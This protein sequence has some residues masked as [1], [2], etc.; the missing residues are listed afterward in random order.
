MKKENELTDVMFR[1]HKFND[2]IVI[3]AIFPYI[4]SNG[5]YVMC[6]EHIGQHSGCSLDWYRTKTKQVDLT[7]PKVIELIKELENIGY[8]LNIIKRVNHSKYLKSYYEQYE[9]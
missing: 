6:Y 7:N 3:T 8:E 5:R 2:N 9:K 4:I 1:Q